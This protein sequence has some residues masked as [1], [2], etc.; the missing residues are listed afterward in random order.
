[1]FATPGVFGEPLGV[2]P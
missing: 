2:T 1:M